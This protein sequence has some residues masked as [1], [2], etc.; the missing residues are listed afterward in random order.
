MHSCRNYFAVNLSLL[1]QK[2]G[3][4]P[5]DHDDL[6][7]N[8]MTYIYGSGFGIAVFERI[9]EQ[10]FNPNISFE[11]GYMLGLRKR[12]LLLKDKKLKNLNTDLMG[13]L[14]KT[15]DPQNISKTVRPALQK[16]LKDKG[17]VL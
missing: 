15:F 2:P 16:W 1:L 17:I 7:W 9:E 3:T 12:V 14:Y 13:K 5:G 4:P 8:I 6:F 10:E 11:V